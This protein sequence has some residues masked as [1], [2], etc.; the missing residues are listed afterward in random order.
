M[1][2]LILLMIGMACLGVLFTLSGFVFLPQKN[3]QRPTPKL[4]M[5]SVGMLSVSIILLFIESVINY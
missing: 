1:H 4:V 5:L 3:K 2:N